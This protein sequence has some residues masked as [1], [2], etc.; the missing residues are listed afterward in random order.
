MVISINLA[1]NFILGTFNRTFDSVEKNR[2]NVR[3]S[4][5]AP[6]L[7]TQRVERADGLE[8]RST[9]R[10]VEAMVAIVDTTAAITDC[11]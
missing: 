1:D 6:D 7:L 5:D 2:L 10:V 3:L 9:L 4:Q 11:H 8:A